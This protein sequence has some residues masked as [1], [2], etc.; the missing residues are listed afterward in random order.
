MFHVKHLKI[1]SV[2][3]FV[4]SRDYFRGTRPEPSPLPPMPRFAIFGGFLRFSWFKAAGWTLARCMVRCHV[5]ADSGAWSGDSM[6]E[7][8]RLP[9]TGQGLEVR[10]FEEPTRRTGSRVRGYRNRNR[11]GRVRGS[12]V[13][14][15]GTGGFGTG[16]FGTGH[17]TTHPAPCSIYRRPRMRGAGMINTL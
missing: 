2:I 3:S 7:G 1:K 17:R 4:F 5:R 6:F 16:G 14:G 10:G 13:R 9:D 11:F 15:F 8:S 12:R